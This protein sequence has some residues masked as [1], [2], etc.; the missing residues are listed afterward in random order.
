M[1]PKGFER[2]STDR[3]PSMRPIFSE[4]QEPAKNQELFRVAMGFGAISKWVKSWSL[5]LFELTM[6]K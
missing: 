1:I 2:V 6:A 3:E 4:K 5:N